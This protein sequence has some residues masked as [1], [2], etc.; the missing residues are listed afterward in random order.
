MDPNAAEPPPGCLVI[1]TPLSAG[2]AE[3]ARVWLAHRVTSDGEP[4]LRDVPKSLAARFLAD[5]LIEGLVT[6][7]DAGYAVP[8]DIA[9]IGYGTD[10]IGDPKFVWLLPGENPELRL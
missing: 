2:M 6:T 10:E 8:L 7:L 5:E 1:L 3:D 9:V 4:E